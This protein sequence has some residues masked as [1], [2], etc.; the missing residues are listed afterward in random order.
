MIAAVTLYEIRERLGQRILG[1]PG[2]RF[3][4]PSGTDSAGGPVGDRAPAPSE[5]LDPVVVIELF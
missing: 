1:R 3:V 5:K 2:F 4:V